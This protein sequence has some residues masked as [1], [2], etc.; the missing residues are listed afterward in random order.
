MGSPVNDDLG[1]AILLKKVKI[2]CFVRSL[3]SN[4]FAVGKYGTRHGEVFGTTH[5]Y[6]FI[7][8]H[9]DVRIDPVQLTIFGFGE[10][11][12]KSQSVAEI[13]VV[14]SS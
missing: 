5:A 7:S 4:V 8:F 12:Y 9:T 11:I 3:R 14:R 10:D 13:I 2:D 1:S 6:E